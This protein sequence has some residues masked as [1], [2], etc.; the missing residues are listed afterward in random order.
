M[1]QQSKR[2][3]RMKYDPAS[4]HGSGADEIT[5]ADLE[6]IPA[7]DNGGMSRRRRISWG[8]CFVGVGYGSFLWLFS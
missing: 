3:V 1:I 8:M 6:F 7:N 2:M 5:F 4:R